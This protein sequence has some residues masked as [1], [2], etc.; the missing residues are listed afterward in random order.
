M[1]S[2]KMDW[3]NGIVIDV[4]FSDDEIDR[5]AKELILRSC[6][7]PATFNMETGQPFHGPK[8]GFEELKRR[9]YS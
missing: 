8:L 6:G 2:R 5:R 1:P 7:K 4:D 9:G 3:G